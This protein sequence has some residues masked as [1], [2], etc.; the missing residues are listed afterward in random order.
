MGCNF[1]QLS[2]PIID[3]N[4]MRFFFSIYFYLLDIFENEHMTK[5]RSRTI[6][7]TIPSTLANNNQNYFTLSIDNS[8]HD[9]DDYDSLEY[10]FSSYGFEGLKFFKEFI[11]KLNNINHLQYILSN[12][13]IGNQLIIKYTNRIDNKDFIR[14]FASVFRVKIK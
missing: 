5:S 3:F 6:I 13:I 8:N 12:W 10:Q 7:E 1:T 2:D 9:D 4:D 14:A 11:L